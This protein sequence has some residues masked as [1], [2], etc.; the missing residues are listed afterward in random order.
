MKKKEKKIFEIKNNFHDVN[1]YGSIGCDYFDIALGQR[2]F[3][4]L[5]RLYPWDHIPGVFI[6]RIAGGHDCH[7]DKLEYKFYNNSNNLIVSNSKKLNYEILNLLEG[8]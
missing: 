8:E 3:A 1:S 2:N 7:F 5:S 6:V 4:I